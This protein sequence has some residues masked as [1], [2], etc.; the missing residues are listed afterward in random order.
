MR[1]VYA[2]VLDVAVRSPETASQGFA[3]LW[4]TATEWVEMLYMEQWRTP[5]RVVANEP[6][7]AP[8]PHHAIS[9][10]R[11]GVSG[12]CELASLEWSYPDDQD[13]GLQWTIAAQFARNGSKLEA[14]VAIR[15]VS[16]YPIA[17]PLSYT[18]KRPSLVD[19]ILQHFTCSIGKSPIPLKSR[20]LERFDIDLF[21]DEVLC[22]PDRWLPIVAISP[23]QGTRDYLIDP[24]E[25]Q[26]TLLGHA[27]VV[28]F[29]DVFAG[30]AWTD[31]L[32]VKE[33]SCYLGAVRLYWPGFTRKAKPP[34]HPLFMADSIRFHTE[35]HQPL[36]QHLFRTL[37]AV[38]GF[39]FSNPPVARLVREAIDGFKQARFHELLKNAK[40]HEESG[41]ILQELE[42]AWDQIKVLQQERDEIRN[43]VA[44]L[45]RELEAQKEAW[46][47]YRGQRPGVPGQDGP[48]PSSLPRAPVRTVVEAVERACADF[49]LTLIFL[50][51]ALESARQSPYRGAE[52][53]YALFH[54]LDEVTRLWQQKGSLGTGWHDALKPKG[55]D[56]AEFISP[57]AKGKYGIE[58]TF[59]YEGEP[60]LFQHHVTIGARSPDTCISIHWHRDEERKRLVIGWCGKHLS[61]TQS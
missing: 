8:L 52:K 20:E 12:V 50:P 51:D 32:G 6:R 37:V 59:R 49:T 30:R 26:Q 19:K 24:V 7:I 47:G 55:F 38:S 17:K 25:L 58:Y 40:A 16:T 14:S 31:A 23:Q 22:S 1:T 33:L 2:C 46:Q 21:V 48:P 34:E 41:Q 13:A 42:R 44:E 43:Q 27:Q 9:A 28:S 45:S 61:N 53:V 10:Q 39:R 57:T 29:K 5:C 60:I 18:L 35:Q 36:G 56:Y 11:D 15:I 54:A 4:T 3:R